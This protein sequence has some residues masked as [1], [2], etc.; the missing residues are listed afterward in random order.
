M[1]KNV[2]VLIV[3]LLTITISIFPAYATTFQGK[4]LES[5]SVTL[6]FGT[7]VIDYKGNIMPF[8]EKVEL[9]LKFRFHYSQK[10]CL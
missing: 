5:D 2:T 9:K 3:M 10:P 6:K 1:E 4:I 7:D 8:I